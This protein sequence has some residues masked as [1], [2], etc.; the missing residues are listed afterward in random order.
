MRP[1]S[2]IHSSLEMVESELAKFAQYVEQYRST[3][4]IELAKLPRD[5]AD[6]L[7]SSEAAVKN[8][9]ITR[10][11]L[12]WVAGAHWVDLSDGHNPWLVAYLLDDPPQLDPHDPMEN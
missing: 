1:A 3:P 8:L 4:V 10:D 12:R 11:V 6:L 7:R 9:S 5:T 2:E